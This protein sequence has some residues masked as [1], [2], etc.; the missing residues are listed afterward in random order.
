MLIIQYCCDVQG[1]RKIY[2][3]QPGRPVEDWFCVASQ[4]L[5]VLHGCGRG[6][7]RHGTDNV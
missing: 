3:M 1:S 4:Q 2:C 5:L 7:A 6:K